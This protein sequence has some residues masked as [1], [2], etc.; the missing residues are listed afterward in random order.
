MVC[1]VWATRASGFG[2]TKGGKLIRQW[3]RNK[4]A[5][6]DSMASAV[7]FRKVRRAN[8]RPFMPFDNRDIWRDKQ[9]HSELI[10][11]LGILGEV[12]LDIDYSNIFY[13]TDTGR[14][15]SN[16]FNIR[17]TVESTIDHS[18]CDMTDLL[19]HIAKKP[20]SA[21]I[22]STHPERWPSTSLGYYYSL[23]SDFVSNL[24]KKI[25]TNWIY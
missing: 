2:S 21:F 4:R 20:D 15:W 24:A 10:N 11:R 3:V 13:L 25:L 12:Y 5:M 8:G 7:Q 9:R 18:F 1:S 14:N 22:L 16:S 23:T 17:D 19:S 6:V